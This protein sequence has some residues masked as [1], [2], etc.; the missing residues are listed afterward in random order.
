[1]NI[2]AVSLNNYIFVTLWVCRTVWSLHRASLTKMW[3]LTLISPLLSSFL[4]FVLDS[5][6][7]RG[8]SQFFVTLTTGLHSSKGLV[9]QARSLQSES[10]EPEVV[11]D[12]FYYIFYSDKIYQSITLSLF[13]LHH[14]RWCWEMQ[15]S[16]RVPLQKSLHIS[17]FN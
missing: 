11:S 15:R 1:M 13:S 10:Q 7:N 9:S 16:Q 2:I 3:H 17:F 4:P 14:L 6:L 12:T 8:H 5:H